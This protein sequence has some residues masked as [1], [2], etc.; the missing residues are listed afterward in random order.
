MSNLDLTSRPVEI[1]ATLFNR[2]HRSMHGI[3]AISRVL[4]QNGAAA[5]SEGGT[6]LNGYLVGCL[7]D[8]IHAL[9]EYSID[10]MENLIDRR[11]AHDE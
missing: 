2:L 9:S 10:A 8:A 3:E 1:D 4:S 7:T 11:E 5:E 6:P